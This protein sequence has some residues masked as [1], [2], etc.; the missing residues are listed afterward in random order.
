MS[1][2]ISLEDA[3]KIKFLRSHGYSL[4]EISREL[5]ISK[6]SVLR[7]IK[8]VDILPE[9]LSEWL[10]KR[11]GSRKIRLLKESKAFEEGKSFV[12]N[13][14]K[15]EKLL[16]LSAL[17][18]AEGTKTDFSLSNTDPNLISTFVECVREIFDLS[19]DKFYIN[20]RLYEDL[21]K[22][23]S[24]RFWSQV[25]KIPKEQIKGFNI[26]PGKKKGKLE[27]GMCRVRIARGGDILKK[28]KGINR[29]VFESLTVP[30]AQQDRAPRS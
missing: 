14:S 18:W 23:K 7:Y 12:G 29:A 15:R 11:G 9:Y 20:I 22:E 21:D 6:S 5:K 26:L 8:E 25:V 10:S 16:F 24:L 28:I 2:R 27:Y 19:N 3:E 4:L 17:Y 13:L 30:I 1:K